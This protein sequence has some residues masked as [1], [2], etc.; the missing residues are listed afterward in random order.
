[1]RIAVDGE[2]PDRVPEPVSLAAYRIVQESLTNARRHAVGA[3]VDVTFS[4]QPQRLTLVVESNGGAPPRR[5]DEPHGVGILGMRE[6]A[7]AV[8]GTLTA[9]PVAGGFR[10]D[11]DLPYARS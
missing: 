2:R 4:F 10:V 3:G 1:V 9:R 6:R 7:A 5:D 8:G 11:A